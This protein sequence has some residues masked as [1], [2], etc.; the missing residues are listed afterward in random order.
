MNLTS[1][2]AAKCFI[3]I[4]RVCNSHVNRRLGPTRVSH[5]E[6]LILGLSCVQ[7]M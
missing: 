1:C 7:V 4:G 6:D 5:S 2:D 3:S